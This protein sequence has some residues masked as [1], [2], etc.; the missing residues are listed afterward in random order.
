VAERRNGLITA[1]A[2]HVSTSREIVDLVLAA[3]FFEKEYGP[4]RRWYRY[5]PTTGSGSTKFKVLLAKRVQVLMYQ[6]V[7]RLV[8]TVVRVV[9]IATARY[10]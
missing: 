8:R 7:S 3:Q 10:R 1:H 6:V 4:I 9:Y 2:T 5:T